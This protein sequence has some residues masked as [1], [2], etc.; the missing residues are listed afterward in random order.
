M[1]AIFRG[2]FG[3]LK[4]VKASGDKMAKAVLEVEMAM[5][6]AIRAAELAFLKTF[7]SK[8]VSLIHLLPDD[9]LSD[10]MQLPFFDFTA[11]LLLPL[12]AEKG[13]VK[14]HTKA[15]NIDEYNFAP[16]S[17]AG[18]TVGTPVDHDLLNKYT[19]PMYRIRSL[20]KTAP[21]SSNRP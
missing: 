3:V 18:E 14:S 20:P 6:E 7:A 19:L 8:I 12:L 16:V 4:D 13:T 15:G 9:A 2:N 10:F 17:K 21:S 1:A 5:L 11:D